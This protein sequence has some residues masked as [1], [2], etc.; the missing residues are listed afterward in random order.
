MGD[1][2]SKYHLKKR[3][4]ILFLI[5]HEIERLFTWAQPLTDSAP[6]DEKKTNFVYKNFSEKSWNDYMHLAWTCHPKVAL[7]LALRVRSSDSIYRSIRLFVKSAPANFYDC[8]EALPFIAT[9]QNVKHD[10]PQLVHMLAW[11]P[12]SPLE[13]LTYFSKEYQENPI[14]GMYALQSIQSYPCETLLFLVPQIVQ[15][16]RHTRTDT[17]VRSSTG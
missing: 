13:V 9:P 12:A 15:A 1:Y 7:S 3:N 16:I 5:H 14:T 11:T 4:L 10:L 17:Y 2:K 6:S 8:V